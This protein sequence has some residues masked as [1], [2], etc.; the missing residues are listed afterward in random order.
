MKKKLPK[1]VDITQVMVQIQ[2]QLAKALIKAE[3]FID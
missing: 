2:E 1:N 3:T